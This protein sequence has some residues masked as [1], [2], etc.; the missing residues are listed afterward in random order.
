M[1][2]RCDKVLHKHE[3]D[4]P[5]LLCRDCSFRSR[6]RMAGALQ[7]GDHGLYSILRSSPALFVLRHPVAIARP[8]REPEPAPAQR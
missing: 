5:A 8:P 3:G 1:A 2:A 7:Q 4:V 6:T